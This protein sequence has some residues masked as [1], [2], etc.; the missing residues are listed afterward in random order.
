MINEKQLIL[1]LIFAD[2]IEEKYIN[3]FNWQSYFD[4]LSKEYE[5]KLFEDRVTEN[6]AIVKKL[7]RHDR[8]GWVIPFATRVNNFGAIN[9]PIIGGNY[10]DEELYKILPRLL[11]KLDEE[12]RANKQ[13]G[14]VI[15]AERPYA[16]I[17]KETFEGFG[18][19]VYVFERVRPNLLNS[20]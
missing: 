14:M 10:S 1:D 13:R 4:F 18:Y 8:T 11:E 17:V 15:A 19:Q 2:K 3:P 9:S 7:K 16:H 5:N 6:Y 12:I 20:N